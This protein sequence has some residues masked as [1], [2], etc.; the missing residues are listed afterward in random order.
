MYLNPLAGVY[1][2]NLLMTRECRNPIRKTRQFLVLTSFNAYL[3]LPLVLC[4]VGCV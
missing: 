4:L 2:E 3:H 1:L